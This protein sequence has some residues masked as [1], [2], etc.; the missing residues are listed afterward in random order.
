MNTDQDIAFHAVKKIE[1]IVH[2][3]EEHFVRELLESSGSPGYTII[4]DIAG[5]GAHSFHEGRLL[6]NDEDSLV[7]FV[8]VAGPDTIHRA[9][10]GLKPLFERESGVMFVSE[11]QVVRLERFVGSG[12][13]YGPQN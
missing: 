1:I 12:G 2:G 3:D 10:S 8:A 7:M 6:F 9:A 13:L 4:R 11:V 5:R